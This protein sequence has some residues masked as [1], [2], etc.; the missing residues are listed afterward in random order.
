VVVAS[1]ELVLRLDGCFSLK[2][3]RHVLRSLTDRARRNCQ[4]AAGEVGDNDLWNAAVVG[5][6]CVSNDVRHAESI[7]QGVIDLFDASPEVAVESAVKR[8]ESY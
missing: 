2:D 6:S 4:V 8:I 7:L 1:V 5:A 3:K